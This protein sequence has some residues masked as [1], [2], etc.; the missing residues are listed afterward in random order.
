MEEGGEI[1][2]QEEFYLKF[3]H[4]EWLSSQTI[5]MMDATAKGIYIMLI[6]HQFEDGSLPAE[7][8][9]L[10]RLSGATPKEWKSF[11]PFLDRC[12]PVQEDGL[13]RNPKVLDERE[14]MKAMREKNK[15]N[16]SKGGRPK[17]TERATQE[18][19]KQ[20]PT[21]NPSETQHQTQTKGSKSNS[22]SKRDTNVS[23]PIVPTGD[24]SENSDNT[25][26]LPVVAEVEPP[27][28]AD[29]WEEFAEAYPKRAGDLRKSDG[30]RRFLSLVKQGV[31]ADAII[32]GARRY[33]AYCEALGKVKTEFVKQM[34][35][36][37][38]GRGWE[39]EFE[40]PEEGLRRSRN[41]DT[42]PPTMEQ[43]HEQALSAFGGGA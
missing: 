36:F 35:T 18:K 12:F 22:K 28:T 33:A 30:K 6:S 32:G 16:G 11:E 39:E 29:R 21:V 15:A 3:Y 25:V 17:K 19:P 40:V 9:F 10:Q 37:L 13:R 34:P 41:S 7:P 42:G 5:A 38:N 4:R 26:T 43:I 14:Q 8:V 27:S 31:D 23:P 2:A 20:N 1:M 24:G